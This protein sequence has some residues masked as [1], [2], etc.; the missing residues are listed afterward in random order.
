MSRSGRLTEP[1]GAP[2]KHMHTPVWQEGPIP[3]S[4]DHHGYTD[5]VIG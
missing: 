5:A 3:L 1:P 2:S 4:A